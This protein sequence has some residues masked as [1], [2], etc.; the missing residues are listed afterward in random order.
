MKSS[1]IHSTDPEIKQLVTDLGGPDQS[2]LELC[3]NILDWFDAEKIE[4]S[5]LDVPHSSMSRSDLDVLHTH[6]GI[7]SDFSHLLVSL[8]TAAGKPVQYAHVQQDCYGDRQEHVCVAIQVNNQWQLVDA[9][10]PYRKWY[11]LDCPHQQFTLLS[12]AQMTSY[13]QQTQATPSLLNAPWLHDQIVM[14]TEES[15]GSVSVLLSLPKT[16]QWR[17]D[18]YYHYY[19]ALCSGALVR[20]VATPDHSYLQ[21]SE[22]SPD[23]IWDEKQWSNP[24]TVQELPKKLVFASQQIGDVLEAHKL[25]LTKIIQMV[26]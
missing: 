25:A 5:R 2:A 15:M 18:A 21:F 23:D 22:F 10:D 8:L 3:A 24:C 14:E 12:P 1:Y 17:I 6:S 4:Y 20:Q 9:T 26:A 19:T 7:C 16:H 11:G 13:L